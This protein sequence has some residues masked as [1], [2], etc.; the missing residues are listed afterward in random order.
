MSRQS[1]LCS[2]RS[3][4]AATGSAPHEYVSRQR[5]DLA[6]RQLLTSDRLLVDIA[7]ATGFSSQA[8]FNRAFR[9]AVKRAGV[10]RIR[11]HDLRHT[12][13]SLA[14]A[15]GVNPKVVSERLGHA[16][17]GITLDTYSHVLPT[18]QAEAARAIDEVFSPDP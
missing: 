2:S 6:K 14:L 9:K 17:I 15:A 1:R 3:F 16:N 10:P 11:L 13:A 12:W 4:K 7:Y 8:N 18:M 5:L